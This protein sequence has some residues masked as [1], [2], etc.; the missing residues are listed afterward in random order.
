MGHIDDACAAVLL[1]LRSRGA[2]FFPYLFAVNLG[3]REAMANAVRHGNKYDRDKLVSMELTL[4]R[5]QWLR[6]DGFP[7]RGQ[8]LNGNVS[9]IRWH[10]L[11]L[12]TAGA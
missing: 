12:I 8:G 6:M 7:T 10:L 5:D 4:S 2:R 3:M 9:K 11:K 1:F